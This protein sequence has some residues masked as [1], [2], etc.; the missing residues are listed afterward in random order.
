MFAHEDYKTR[1]K[2]KKKKK[3]P[4]WVSGLDAVFTL[5]GSLNCVNAMKSEKTGV[6]WADAPKSSIHSG[7]LNWE[8]DPLHI[9]Q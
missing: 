1:F 8:L 6:K 9:V 4:Y 2:K 7:F 3:N 5:K